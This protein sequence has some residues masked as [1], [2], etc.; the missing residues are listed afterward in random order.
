[1]PKK[2][3]ARRYK[4]QRKNAGRP[5]K[6]YVPPGIE[7]IASFELLAAGCAKSGPTAQ[8]GFVDKGQ[9]KFS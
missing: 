5:G 6:P 8:C 9:W 4:A 3:S 2:K 1:M 7:E